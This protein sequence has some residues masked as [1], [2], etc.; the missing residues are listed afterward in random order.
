LEP[1]L[2]KSLGTGVWWRFGVK[3]ESRIYAEPKLY[4]GS[5]PLMPGT[6]IGTT[7]FKL[8]SFVSGRSIKGILGMDC[9]RHYCIQLDFEVG[10][11]RF[12]DPDHL[13]TADLGKAYPLT[14]KGN[15]PFIHHVSLTGGTSTNS[16][17]DTGMLYDGQVEKVVIKGHFMTRVRNFLVEKV[18]PGRV[19]H[20]HVLVPECVWD[21]ETNTNLKVDVGE[22]ANILGLRFLARHLVTLDF[23]NGMM[24]LKQT[25]VGPLVKKNTKAAADGSKWSH[26]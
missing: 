26:D 2:G 10:K 5:T 11:M 13:N 3:H 18:V 20:R 7:G 25:S 19:L 1:K 14:F 9:L 12:L 6:N 16:L 17:I 24:Y 4:L 8:L 22:H 23:P 21:G 15:R